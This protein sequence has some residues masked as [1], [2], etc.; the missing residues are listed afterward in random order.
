MIL[1]HKLITLVPTGR[2]GLR[3]RKL[4]MMSTVS[5]AILGKFFDIHGMRD[6]GH[7]RDLCDEIGN[8]QNAQTHFQG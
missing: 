5:K 7:Q 4:E 6:L 8:A 2:Q 1:I 3:L